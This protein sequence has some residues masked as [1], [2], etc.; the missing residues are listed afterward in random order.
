MR[1]SVSQIQLFVMPAENQQG[2]VRVQQDLIWT[3]TGKKCV[4][5][6]FSN[7]RKSNIAICFLPLTLTICLFFKSNKLFKL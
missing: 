6:I 1:L 4:K 3:V 7:K 2:S 5:L